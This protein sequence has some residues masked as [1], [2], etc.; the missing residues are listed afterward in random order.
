MTVS[1]DGTTLVVG[2]SSVS[3]IMTWT[4]AGGW[5]TASGSIAGSG[6]V[7]DVITAGTTYYAVRGGAVL[8]CTG[9]PATANWTA[10]GAYT[11]AVGIAVVNSDLY[12]AKSDGVYNHTQSESISSEPCVAIAGYQGNIYFGKDRRIFRYDNRSTFLFDEL[13]QGFNLTALIPYR[14][15]LFIL[16]YF[17]IRTGYKAAIYY[18]TSSSEN[19]LYTLGDYSADYR[20]YALA[21]SDDEVFF[22]N[23]KRG[24]ADRYDLEVGGITNGP[25][26]GEVGA[27]PFKSMA[28]CEGYL[29]VGRYDN[30]SATDGI[31]KA[32]LQ[33]PTAWNTTGWLT[34][35]EY[36]FGWSNDTKLFKDILVECRALATGQGI[37]V[38]YSTNGGSSYTS[39][40]TTT[41]AADGAATKETYTLNNVSGTTIKL[42]IIL[43]GPGTSTPT[44]T[45]VVVR[46]AR[47]IES[48][49]MWDLRLYIA[50]DAARVTALE[51]SAAK[52]T[53][54]SFTD[55][56]RSTTHNVLIEEL[57]MASM[58]DKEGDSVRPRLRLR[59]V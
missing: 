22:A 35:A 56:D 55:I 16:G 57:A 13:P 44:L 41:Y 8:T 33:N 46:A 30:A 47:C 7:T 45:K 5:A 21:G 26:W 34:T 40:G 28:V 15:V 32:D 25:M 2:L 53:Q 48:T 50:D 24:G 12:V 1:A 19:H 49:D 58:P 51:T 27:I 52:R 4:S 54:L 23:P 17:K 43:T 39:A 14:N 11:T 29:F 59:E 3:A 31:Y 36:D 37:E 20:I 9:N 6:A 38:Q 42:K 10:V 18:V